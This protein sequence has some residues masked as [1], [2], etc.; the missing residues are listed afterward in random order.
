MTTSPVAMADKSNVGWQDQVETLL[1]VW[2]SI[3]D[4]HS[5]LSARHG[6]CARAARA[7]LR[8]RFLVTHLR[9][10]V[11]PKDR[12]STEPVSLAALASSLEVPVSDE[13]RQNMIESKV[14][15]HELTLSP[16]TNSPL[17]FVPWPPLNLVGSRGPL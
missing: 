8:T 5:R 1:E 12:N 11:S 6:R 17:Y 3:D 10:K 2:H 16:S 14:V 15:D 4:Q 9:L 13:H 7:H